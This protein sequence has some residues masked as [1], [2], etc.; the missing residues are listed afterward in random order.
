METTA[1]PVKTPTVSPEPCVSEDPLSEPFAER[2]RL[3]QV[4]AGVV[5]RGLVRRGE[6]AIR[7]AQILGLPKPLPART[8]GRYF[9]GRVPHCRVIGALAQAMHVDPG[10]LAFGDASKAP[11]PRSAS[12]DGY[13]KVD[14][15]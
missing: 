8:V 7:V 5:N 13:D 3:A 1:V 15:L 2:M 4:E 10:W 11:A 9:D 6:I 12:L 14:P